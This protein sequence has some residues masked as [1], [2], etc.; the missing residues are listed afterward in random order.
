MP[1]KR[2]SKKGRSESHQEI[3][4]PVDR[5][6]ESENNETPSR[7]DTP[8]TRNNI[9]GIIQEITRQLRPESSE[10]HTSPLPSTFY[11]TSLLII[12]VCAQ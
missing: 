5:V 7:D 6:A 8:L 2:R 12:C 9:P 3:A 4:E 10:A 11:L 1:P